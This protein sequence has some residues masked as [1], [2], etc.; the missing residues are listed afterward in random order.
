MRNTTRRFDLILMDL[1]LPDADR[2][3]LTDSLR[4]LPG[5][6][7]VPVI[8]LTAND[9]E[10]YRGACRERGMQAF[11]GKPVQAREL[12]CTVRRFLCWD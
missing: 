7:D 12:V 8:A 1:Q 6:A 2:L 9:S 3:V 4:E 5:Y 11:L 10:E